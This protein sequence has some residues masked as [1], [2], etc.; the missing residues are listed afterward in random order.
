MKDVTINDLR[1]LIKEELEVVLTNDEA[2][3]F[4][5]VDVRE[6]LN[7]IETQDSIVQRKVDDFAKALE[8]SAVINLTD[9]E[10]A[11]ISDL[12]RAKAFEIS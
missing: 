7:E 5:D 1:K 9:D 2:K 4:F 11:T 8:D 12:F 6:Q 10:I 3:E